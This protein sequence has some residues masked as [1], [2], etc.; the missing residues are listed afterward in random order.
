MANKQK[1]IDTFDRIESEL[2]GYAM[3]D[4]MHVVQ[5][6]AKELDI[7]VDEVRSVLIDHWTMAGGG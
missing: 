5:L 1:I 2:G 4:A 7:E 3:S 6:T